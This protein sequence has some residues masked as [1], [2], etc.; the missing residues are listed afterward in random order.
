MLQPIPNGPL[1]RPESYD[2]DSPGSKSDRDGLSPS[3]TD[4]EAVPLAG[5]VSN[6]S[7][8]PRIAPPPFGSDRDGGF[9][10]VGPAEA[11]V[12][13]E[14][15]GWPAVGVAVR[16]VPRSATSGRRSVVTG[17]PDGSPHNRSH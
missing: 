10:W 16:P 9:G 12:L 2:N 1:P 17:H 6:F 3:G 11:G 8:R 4:S 13:V 7:P 14:A 5:L 15:D